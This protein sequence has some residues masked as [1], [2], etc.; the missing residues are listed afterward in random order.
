MYVYDFKVSFAFLESL[1]ISG[2]INPATIKALAISAIGAENKIPFNPNIRGKIIIRGT[3]K[4][5]WRS[6]D[7][8]AAFKGW[9]VDWK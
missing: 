3:S 8:R 4:E 1:F 2:I 6:V 9:P 7:K 5:S